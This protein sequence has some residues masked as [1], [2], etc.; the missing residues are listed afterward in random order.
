MLKFQYFGHPIQRADSLEKPLMLGNIEGKRR[1]EQQRIRWLD[2]I[3]YSMN[4]NLGKLQEIAEDRGAWHAAVYEIAKSRTWLRDWTTTTN[5]SL[6]FNQF[7][8]MYFEAL[9]LA[10]WTFRVL[11]SLAELTL[12]IIMK[13]LVIFFSY[14]WS[15]S[16]LWNLT[17]LILIY[18]LQSSLD[19]Y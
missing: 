9:L 14:L 8:C 2:S 15:Y 10:A 16:H 4:M 18:P 6:Q 12:I 19:W 13:S 11:K 1:L 17:W 5:I 3:T 7:Y